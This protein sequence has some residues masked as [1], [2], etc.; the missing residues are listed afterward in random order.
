MLLFLL[1]FSAR[2]SLF[3]SSSYLFPP[4]SQ[5]AWGHAVIVVKDPLSDLPFFGS[6]EFIWSEITNPFFFTCN[7]PK[8]NT[9]DRFLFGC[10][11]F[12]VLVVF[13]VSLSLLDFMFCLSKLSILRR[14]SL[15]ALAKSM[16]L[17]GNPRPRGKYRIPCQW[18]LD[19]GSNA[20]DPVVRIPQ[21]KISWIPDSTNEGFQI[22]VF[23]VPYMR[24]STLE[25]RAG[26]STRHVFKY[27]GKGW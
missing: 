18:N 15:L 22:P 14:A 5:G 1:V 27:W 19:S 7:S 4:S 6:D 17:W 13:T 8:E 23:R 9:L 11:F 12:T 26:L 20:Q 21:S 10:C 25:I 16:Y 24:R 3:F 2:I